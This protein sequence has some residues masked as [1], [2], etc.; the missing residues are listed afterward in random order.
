MHPLRQVTDS[1]AVPSTAKSRTGIRAPIDDP[2]RSVCRTRHRG[3]PDQRT[4]CGFAGP[5]RKPFGAVSA[6]VD[7]RTAPGTSGGRGRLDPFDGHGYNPRA[8]GSCVSAMLRLHSKESAGSLTLLPCGMDWSDPFW[9]HGGDGLSAFA[10]LARCAVH[11]CA[12]TSACRAGIHFSE[13]VVK[14]PN[15]KTLRVL[16][17]LPGRARNETLWGP[18]GIEHACQPNLSTGTNPPGAPVDDRLLPTF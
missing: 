1:E 2:A 6:D 14:V 7:E 4:S 5:V 15:G 3:V 17:R 16:C 9:R 8:R 12:F 10:P 13:R 11:H 18:P